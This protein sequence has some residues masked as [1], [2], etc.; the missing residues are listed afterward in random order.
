MTSMRHDSDVNGYYNVLNE[1]LQ[2]HER[3]D[4]V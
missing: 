4:T 3:V 1:V 2:L